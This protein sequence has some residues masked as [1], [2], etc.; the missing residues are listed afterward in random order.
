MRKI[1]LILPS[2]TRTV[3]YDNGSIWD[4][5]IRTQ[6]ETPPRGGGGQR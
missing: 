4:I 1:A 2:Y 6:A 3:N 5:F